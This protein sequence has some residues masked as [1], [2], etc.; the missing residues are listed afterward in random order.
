VLI[1]AG[2]LAVAGGSSRG[3]ARI[4][5]LAGYP[6]GD[7]LDHVIRAVE[8]WRGLERET[9]TSLLLHTDGGGLSTGT[10]VRHQAELLSSAGRHAQLMDTR[11]I[12]R[13]WPALS[14]P[15]NGPVLYQR[16]SGV[17][18]ASLALAAL[19]ASAKNAGA[20][21]VERTT[22]RALD[23]D[24]HGVRI[25]TNAGSIR[26]SF[27]VVTAGPWSRDL[28]A[29]IGISL[30]VRVCEQTVVWFPW[31]GPAPPIL[32]EYDE[33]G[34]YWLLDPGRGLKAALHNPGRWIENPDEAY[35]V[36][37]QES[38]RRVAQWVADCYP[39]ADSRPSAVE[40]CRYTW[41]A[42]ERFV[43]ERHGPVIVGS[44]CSGRGF[45]HAPDTAELLADLA[46]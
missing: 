23:H 5:H 6:S 36:G 4:W 7:Y 28:L 21:L 27:V 43:I 38:V 41:A 14:L 45:Q 46:S 12:S 19:L 40:T 42:D 32:I 9:G 11:D 39:S 30:D 34:P 13:R 24:S 25:E 1:E 8:G 3:T 33:P 31:K 15:P 22:V 2:E 29:T 17:I 44:A 35:G 20:D 37:H 18:L 26:A 10:E 16:D